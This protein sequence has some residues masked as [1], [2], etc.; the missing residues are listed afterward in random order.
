MRS[1]L[2]PAHKS[3]QR[4]E[5][6]AA[7]TINNELTLLSHAFQLAVKE[8]EW[9][10][11]NTVQRVSKE[12]VHNLIERWLTAEEEHVSYS[13]SGLAARDHCLRG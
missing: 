11:E 3:K 10:A 5:G 12:K 7:K 1:S 2:L 9:V 4:A 8:W 6:A 13:A